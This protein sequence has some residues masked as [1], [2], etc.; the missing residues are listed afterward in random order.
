MYRKTLG[1][2]NH[3]TLSA[4]FIKISFL[5]PF[6]KNSFFTK[7]FETPIYSISFLTF[8]SIEE[9]NRLN[10][11]IVNVTHKIIMIEKK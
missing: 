1:I 5:K 6:L 8:M 9:F 4:I 11:I 7:F 10:L 2:D 3:T